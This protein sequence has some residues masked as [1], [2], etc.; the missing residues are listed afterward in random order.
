MSHELLH[1]QFLVSRFVSGASEDSPADG[2]PVAFTSTGDKFY[3]APAV[4]IDIYRW[5]IITQDLLD[6]G[7]GFTISMEFR[8]TVGS[9]TDRAAKQTIDRTTDVAAGT[10]LYRDVI[11]AVAQ[12]SGD[13][14]LTGGTTTQTS[15]LNVGPAGPLHV[16]PGE[17]VVF[18]VTDAADT[19][20]TGRIWVEYV[21]SDFAL[22]NA[23]TTSD[24]VHVT[25]GTGSVG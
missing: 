22:A 11:L 3:V 14:T 12:A 16:R 5:G 17:E 19:A 2:G 7:A 25:K 1:K 18:E 10:V 8:P 4:P 9:D 21:E 23:V 20:G 15:L 13:D 6:V 24:G